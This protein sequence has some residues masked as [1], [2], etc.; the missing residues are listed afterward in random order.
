MKAIEQTISSKNKSIA[1]ADLEHRTLGHEIERFHKEQDAAAGNL[2]ALENE[3]EWIADEKELFGRSGTL[4]DFK[5]Q[6]MADSK[7]RRKAVEERLR[8]MK[9]KINPKV[10]A[11]IDSVEK[12]ETSLK[13]NMQIVIKDKKKIEET[14]VK[15]DEYKKKALHKT[16]T[17]VNGDFGQIFNELLPGSFAK[18]DPPEG[19]TIS[20]GLEVKVRLGKVWKESLTELS[21]G[22]R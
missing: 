10:M 17:K 19:K 7:A 3:Y 8:G 22:Q 1:D 4:Y 18:L 13:R 9:N 12:K 15:L 2:Q 16:W 21:G 5:G 20:D 11:M 14:I 6:N